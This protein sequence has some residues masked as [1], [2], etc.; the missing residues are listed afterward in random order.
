MALFQSWVGGN[1]YQVLLKKDGMRHVTTHCCFY[2]SRVSADL[3]SRQGFRSHGQ[4][5]QSS[6]NGFD[7]SSSNFVQIYLAY[8]LTTDWYFGHLG[9]VAE[10]GLFKERSNACSDSSTNKHISSLA[11]TPVLFALRPLSRFAHS[12]LHQS[13]PSPY[14]WSGIHSHLT[15]VWSWPSHVDGRWPCNGRDCSWMGF[16]FQN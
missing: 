2:I 14:R 11:K 8:H 16:F 5:L 9:P 4:A 3:H 7:S 12:E 1:G 13:I 6:F 10:N 15:S